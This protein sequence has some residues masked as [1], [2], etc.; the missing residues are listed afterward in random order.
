VWC[1]TAA[2]E[3]SSKIWG[4]QLAQAPTAHDSWS[5]DSVVTSPNVTMAEGLAT[6]AGF[7]LPLRIVR[8]SLDEFLSICSG[9]N[10][11]RTQLQAL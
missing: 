1:A 7:D 2:V 11:M 5:D 6:G 9:A 10:I 3:S 4:V 8:E